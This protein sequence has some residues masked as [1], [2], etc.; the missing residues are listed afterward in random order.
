VEDIEDNRCPAIHEHDMAPDDH[1]C[2]VRWRWRQP[3][4]KVERA[5][6]N[7]LLQ[8]WRKC[9]S[10]NKLLFQAGRQLISLGQSGRQSISMLRIPVPH[11]F[12]VAIPIIVTVIF[13]TVTFVVFVIAVFFVSFAVSL[14]LT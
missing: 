4:F 2:A 1:V 3:P 10:A 6:L 12:P 14:S 9:S 13:T 7:F 11:L 8:T 5:R